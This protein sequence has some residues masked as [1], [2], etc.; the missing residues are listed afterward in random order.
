MPCCAFAA[1]IV[2][3]ILLALAAVKRALLGRG[4]AIEVRNAAVEWR[5]DAPAAAIVAPPA[6]VAWL[7]SRRAAGGLALAAALEI[8][9]VFGA[10]YGL[11]EHAGH[12]SSAEHAAHARPSVEAAQPTEE[13]M[14]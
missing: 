11:A 3:Q 8:A 1:C 12:R 14:P 7:R 9:L 5:L 13:V 2:G 6:R 4:S 10:L